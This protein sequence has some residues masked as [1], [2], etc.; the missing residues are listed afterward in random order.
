[1]DLYICFVLIFVE[2]FIW[3]DFFNKLGLFILL[4]KIK[5]LLN[6]FIGIFELLFKLVSKK[7]IFLGVCF[8]VCRIFNLILFIW[9]IFLCLINCVFDGIF[10]YFNVFLFLLDIYIFVFKCLVILWI[11]EV[12]LV[13]ICVF[14]VCVIVKFLEF[15]IFIYF[16]KLWIGFIIIVFFVCW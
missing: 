13:W 11:F 16:D 4:I 2:F 9:M 5:L 14:V 10:L 7:L 1:M 12:K 8:G 15:V 3:I 6:N